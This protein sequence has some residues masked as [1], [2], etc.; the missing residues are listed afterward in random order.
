MRD[1]YR[2]VSA[3]AMLAAGVVL[4]YLGFWVPPIGEISNSVLLFVSQTLIYAG[5]ALGIDVVIDHKIRN[6]K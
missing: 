5:A 4:A 6:M 3:V 2:R 1:Y